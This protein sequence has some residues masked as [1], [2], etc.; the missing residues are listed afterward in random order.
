MKIK[1][2][3]SKIIS[4]LGVLFVLYAV[5]LFA[6]NEQIEQ[7]A[8]TYSENAV[9]IIKEQIEVSEEEPE[10]E[11]SLTLEKE[12]S[13]DDLTEETTVDG[14]TYIG[15]LYFESLGLEL[16]VQSDWAYEKLSQTPCVYQEEPFSIAAHNY[17]SHFGKISNLEI[18]DIV[19]LEDTSGTEFVFKVVSNTI[20]NETEIEKLQDDTY[21]LTLFTCN[22][23]N[24]NERILVRLMLL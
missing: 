13:Y 21:D 10:Q 11:E 5:F 12:F 16:A 1:N 7:S 9:E 15:I 14:E 2:K 19:V 22:Y 3:I 24:N 6:K 23:N 4:A 18:D 20:V 17:N 8:K